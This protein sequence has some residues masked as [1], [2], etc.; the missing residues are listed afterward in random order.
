MS[1]S[2]FVSAAE[3][4]RVLGVSTG[5]LAQLRRR[6]SGPPWV[7][8]NNRIYYRREDLH[9]QTAASGTPTRPLLK[10]TDVAR[11]LGVTESGLSHMRFRRQGPDF[12]VLGQRSIRYA[13]EA[14]ERYLSASTV[15]GDIA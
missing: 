3:A 11:L 8:R 5:A 6:K 7:A 12:I 15:A 9:P 2:N 10:P 1:T 4:A 13:P 14:I